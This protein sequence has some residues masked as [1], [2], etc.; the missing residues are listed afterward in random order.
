MRPREMAARAAS[1]AADVRIVDRSELER[2]FIVRRSLAFG[3]GAAQ[4][5]LVSEQEK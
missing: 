1:L 4:V 2:V 5:S 3:W